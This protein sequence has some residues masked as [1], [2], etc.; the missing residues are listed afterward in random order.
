MC[1]LKIEGVCILLLFSAL[2]ALSPFFSRISLG[3]IASE[4][5]ARERKRKSKKKTDAVAIPILTRPITWHSPLFSFSLFLF[6]AAS[7][8]RSQMN[9]RLECSNDEDDGDDG[10]CRLNVYSMFYGLLVGKK[11]RERERENANA[12]TQ[13]GIHDRQEEKRKGGYSLALLSCAIH[14]C[15][16]ARKH[17]W[18]CM[19]H[20]R[21]RDIA[22]KRKVGRE[23]ERGESER[24][25]K[26]R[27]RVR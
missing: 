24:S 10:G 6:L 19:Y 16:Q 22:W 5:R 1:I 17:K 14:F 13:K 23:G 15:E 2:F 4:H 3:R 25:K 20:D 7:R 8:S 27:K 12:C 26:H 11:E 18:P 21:M 9:N